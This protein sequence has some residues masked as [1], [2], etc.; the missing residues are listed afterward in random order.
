MTL[1]ERIQQLPL[2]YSEV[3]YEDK[4][5]GVTKSEFN[6]GN[7]YKIYAEELGGNNCISLNYYCTSAREILKP[8][9]M[10]ASKVIHFLE[11]YKSIC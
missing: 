8:C 6:H 9:E 4:K 5:Y 7:S 1:L 2:G 11:N 10:P 3:L